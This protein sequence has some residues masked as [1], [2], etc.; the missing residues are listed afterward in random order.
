MLDPAH[1]PSERN[2]MVADPAPK[3]KPKPKPPPDPTPRPIHEP[4]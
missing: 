2:T 1:A 4:N 3:P